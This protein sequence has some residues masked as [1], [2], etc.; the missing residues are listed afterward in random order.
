MDGD[1]LAHCSLAALVALSCTLVPRTELISADSGLLED[2]E[3]CGDSSMGTALDAS[4]LPIC[5]T[6]S[7][8]C[9]PIASTSFLAAFIITSKTFPV[10]D[11]FL[12]DT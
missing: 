6:I 9:Q 8:V 3:V 1:P 10:M 5:V 4:R 7:K 2:F 11:A 12:V